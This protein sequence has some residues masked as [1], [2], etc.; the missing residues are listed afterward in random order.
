MI[1]RMFAPDYDFLLNKADQFAAH[2]RART[3]IQQEELFQRQWLPLLFRVSDLDDDI[4]I[5]DGLEEG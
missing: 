3:D 5:E 1:V 4:Q 2:R